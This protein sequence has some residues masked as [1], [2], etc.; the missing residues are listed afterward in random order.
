MLPVAASAAAI[1][2]LL[3]FAV[4]PARFPGGLSVA[5]YARRGELLGASVSGS[6][7]WRLPP[8]GSAPPERFVRA[9]V[10]Y[11]D[12][13]FFCH[14]G[15]DPLALARAA[16]QNAR[17]GRIVSGGSTISMQA[18]RLARPGRERELGE[19]AIEA[20]MALRFE[21]FLGKKG[22]LAIYAEN[23]P[24]GGNVVGLEAASFRFFG[25]GPEFLS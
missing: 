11:E 13:R 20:L 24:F 22:I 25:R 21:L 3:L 23:A 4:P 17:A 8:S 16:R 6:G 9:L 12:K 14:A 10:A 15:I 5:V 7:Q 2:L 18:A 19:K 1:V